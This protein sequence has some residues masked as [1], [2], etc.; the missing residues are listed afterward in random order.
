MDRLGADIF[1]LPFF[2][3]DLDRNLLSGAIPNLPD[4]LEQL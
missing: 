2:S 4:S 3:R 1:S